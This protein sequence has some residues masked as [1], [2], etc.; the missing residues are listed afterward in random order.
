MGNETTIFRIGTRK[1]LLA[2]AQSQWVAEAVRARHPEISVELVPIVTGG[3]RYF[4]PLHA[5][6]GKGLFTAELELALHEG[7]IDLAV[8]SAKDLP[9]AMG[10]GL[11]I[12]AVPKREDARDALVWPGGGPVESLPRGAAVGTSSPRRGAQL[13]TVRPDLRIVPL[14]GNVET[15]LGK[16]LVEG[17]I[18][19]AV[20]AMAGLVRSHL[21]EPHRQHVQAMDVERFVPA[22]GQGALAVQAAGSNQ[23]ALALAAELDDASSHQALEAERLIVRRLGAD[24]RSSLAVHFRKLGANWE[25]LLFASRLDGGSPYR[26][27][28]TTAAPDAGAEQLAQTSLHDGVDELLGH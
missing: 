23:W 7:R 2:M 15:R 25:G 12:A 8:H 27:A 1:S 28:V 20:L 14:R 18:N 6:G 16:A 17:Q 21:L 11:V 10:E 22:A 3:D 19:A 13:L 9:A 26:Q 24:C 5:V 4:G